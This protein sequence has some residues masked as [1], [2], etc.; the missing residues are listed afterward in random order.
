MFPLSFFLCGRWVAASGQVGREGGGPA[1]VSSAVEKP[2]AAQLEEICDLAA[3]WLLLAPNL[4]LAVETPARYCHFL[5][6]SFHW[7][8]VGNWA[9]FVGGSVRE[10]L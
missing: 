8:K 7:K 10:N 3:P 4:C 9:V 5:F 2:A 6:K 1:S